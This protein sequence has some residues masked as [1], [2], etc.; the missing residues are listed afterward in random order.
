MV[1]HEKN[2]LL[3]ELDNVRDLSRQL[4]RLVD[5]PELLERLRN[6]IGR[7]KTVK[8][9]MDEMERLYGE[10]VEDTRT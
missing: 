4:Q 6:G 2:G 3:F 1:E 10:L 9:S 8:D 5:Q 7:V